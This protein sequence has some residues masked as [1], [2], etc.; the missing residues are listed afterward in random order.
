MIKYRLALLPFILLITTLPAL[1]QSNY[2]RGYRTG[3]I[4]GYCFNAEPC[5]VDVPKIKTKSGSYR[6]GYAYGF[7]TAVKNRTDITEKDYLK[8]YYDI[9]NALKNMSYTVEEMAFTQEFEKVKQLYL[10]GDYERCISLCDQIDRLVSNDYRTSMFKGLSLLELEDFKQGRKLL[11]IAS[12]VAPETAR[13]V[14]DK[15]LEEVSDGTYKAHK[16]TEEGGAAATVALPSSAKP[17]SVSDAAKTVSPQQA[18]TKT[19]KPAGHSLLLN[20]K[21]KY[22]KGDYAGA[23]AELTKAIETDSAA[24]AYYLRALAKEKLGDSYGA[25]ND[26]AYLARAPV[27]DESVNYSEVLLRYGNL[28]LQQKKYSQVITEMDALIKHNDKATLPQA[29][30]N[31]GSAKIFNGDKEGG[32]LDLSKAGELG[33]KAAY[34]TIRENCK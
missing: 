5:R 1:S 24:E 16:T 20:G 2:E 28:L 8:D 23:V 4:N 9:F 17:A 19:G 27:L 6:T 29:Y 31:R 26:Y 7:E 11:R 32:C 10:V 34:E 14:I 15:T 21:Q 3:Y 18:V 30:F 12:D 13:L 22:N 25:A 33:Y